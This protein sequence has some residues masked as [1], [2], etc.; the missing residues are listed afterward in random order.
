MPIVSNEGLD[1]PLLFET[2]NSFVGGVN[3]LSAAKLLEPSQ[4][5]ELVNVDID[6]V[7]NA[8]TRRGTTSLAGTSVPEGTANIQ[9]NYNV[10]NPHAIIL[11]S[12]TFVN[13]VLYFTFQLDRSQWFWY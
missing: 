9:G 3:N 7:G 13:H 6:R 1:D 2:T 4:S 11:D 8:V 10:G 5:V 12:R